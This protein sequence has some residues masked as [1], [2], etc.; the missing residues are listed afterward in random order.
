MGLIWVLVVV[1]L[2]LSAGRTRQVP[3]FWTQGRPTV[4]K[5]AIVVLVTFASLSSALADQGDTSRGSRI[6]G[7]VRRATRSNLTET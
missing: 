2:V 1:V 7:L 6:S 5:F 3:S 4:S